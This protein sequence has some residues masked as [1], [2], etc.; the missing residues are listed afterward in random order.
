M[1]PYSQIADTELLFP[2]PKATY[3]GGISEAGL[4]VA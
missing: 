1:R 4:G 2:M 3:S